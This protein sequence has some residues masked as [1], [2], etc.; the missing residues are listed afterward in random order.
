MRKAWF[1]C[2]DYTLLL[3]A[4]QQNHRHDTHRTQYGQVLLRRP[5]YLFTVGI[6][7]WLR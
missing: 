2:V 5:L 1:H 7:I 6:T 3:K 4:K